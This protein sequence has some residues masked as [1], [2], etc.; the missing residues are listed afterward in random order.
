MYQHFTDKIQQS[1]GIY[2]EVDINSFKIIREEIF[3]R[4]YIMF[5]DQFFQVPHTKIG[6]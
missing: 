2:F 1:Q 5:K 3:L 6:K 4:E